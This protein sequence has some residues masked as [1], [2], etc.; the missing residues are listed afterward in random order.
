VL[1]ARSTTKTPMIVIGRPAMAVLLNRRC[2]VTRKSRPRV[3]RRRIDPL[4]FI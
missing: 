1:K 4:D 2:L 3:Q